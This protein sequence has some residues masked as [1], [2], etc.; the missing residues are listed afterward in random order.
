MANR[1]VIPTTI[2]ITVF[3]V[4]GIVTPSL[5]QTGGDQVP[6][7]ARPIP[8]KG[9]VDILLSP[10][11]P[12]DASEL[13]ERVRELEKWIRDY[14]AWK[15][16]ADQWR[17]R[18]EPGWFSARDRRIRPD[19]PAWLFDACRDLI[20]DEGTLPDA[21]RLLAD[22]QDDS[23]A[24][25]RTTI[26]T[27]R[28]Q[29]E[30]P[31]KTTWWEHLHL[32]ALWF[33]PQPHASV[34]GVVGIHATIEV[35]GRWQI[36]VAPGALLLNLPT[37]NGAREWKPATDFG[38]S[39]RLFDFTV[40]GARRTGVLHVNIAKAWVLGGP[41]GLINTSIDLVGFSVTLKKSP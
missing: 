13:A 12:P 7:P 3:C 37:V 1:G 31:T 16:W 38:M 34:Y 2:T 23:A 19:P 14:S 6:L 20:D 11:A 25:L 24:A 22:W 32:D 35:H 28:T 15:Q 10:F 27:Q 8:L 36:F 4:A 39:V 29:Q 40:P 9:Q 33:M 5:G 26:L 30:A 17:N 41:A 18:I 21:C